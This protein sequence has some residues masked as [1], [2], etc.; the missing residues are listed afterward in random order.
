VSQLAGA[1]CGV[2]V[3]PGIYKFYTTSFPIGVP[4]TQY[5]VPFATVYRLMSVVSA[6]GFHD[7]PK[8]CLAIGGAHIFEFRCLLLS[9]LAAHNLLLR[10]ASSHLTAW[11]HADRAE[12][13]SL[14]AATCRRPLLKYCLCRFL[15]PASWAP[16]SQ[17]T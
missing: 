1:F 9:F 15:Q 14:P 10:P 3:A 2:L 13:S 4:G 5:S 17:P 7:L 12:S 11:Y 6:N 16:R 8:Y